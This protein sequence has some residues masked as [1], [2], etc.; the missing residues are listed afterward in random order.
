MH[1]VSTWLLNA[2][3]MK[4]RCLWLPSGTLIS[5]LYS[6]VSFLLFEPI[7]F[8][9]TFC[10]QIPLIWRYQIHQP[11]LMHSQFETD[12]DPSTERPA[13]WTSLDVWW[14]NLPLPSILLPSDAVHAWYPSTFWSGVHIFVLVSV[15]HATMHLFMFDILVFE[16]VQLLCTTMT[17]LIGCD[18]APYYQCLRDKF[19]YWNH[20]STSI[21]SV[22]SCEFYL[23]AL[24]SMSTTRRHNTM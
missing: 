16:V 6:V 23:K 18:C 20:M 11:F 5:S 21:V 14:A 2:S 22:V 3:N 15:W 12:L 9:Y 1:S 10:G 7:I 4:L 24:T 8:P 13:W 17:A 19:E